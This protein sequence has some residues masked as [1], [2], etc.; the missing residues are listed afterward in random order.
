[1]ILQQ[2]LHWK[3]W[4]PWLATFGLA[5]PGSL[6]LMGISVSVSSMCIRLIDLKILGAS[7]G[8]RMGAAWVIRPVLEPHKTSL[9]PPE[10]C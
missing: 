8:L 4:Q 6:L 9:E 3:S 2:L 10:G 5:L 7:P 1:V